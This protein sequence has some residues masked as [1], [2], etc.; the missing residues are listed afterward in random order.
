M[1]LGQSATFNPV[2]CFAL[3]RKFKLPFKLK[4]RNNLPDLTDKWQVRQYAVDK[5]D[6]D[7]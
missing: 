2:V 7:L 4:R 5:D 1:I 6:Y 3:T